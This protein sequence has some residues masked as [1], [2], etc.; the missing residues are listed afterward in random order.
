MISGP[1]TSKMANTRM[2]TG[3]VPTQTGT[4]TEPKEVKRP[5]TN[6]TLFLRHFQPPNG[7]RQ[8]WPGPGY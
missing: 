3:T 2:L 1:P 5:A 4:G 7:R 8:R 6:R